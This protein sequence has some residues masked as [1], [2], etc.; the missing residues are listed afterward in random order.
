[1]VSAEGR[2]GVAG[3]GTIEFG[4]TVMATLNCYFYGEHAA[5]AA[6]REMRR[7][8]FSNASRS[9]RAEPVSPAASRSLSYH[10]SV[11]R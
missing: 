10:G 7:P 1:M 11:S 5:D 4:D 9:Q 2:L 8:G 3:F 6:A